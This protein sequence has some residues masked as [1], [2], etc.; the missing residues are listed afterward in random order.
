MNVINGTWR[1]QQLF[2]SEL[3]RMWPERTE[4]QTF[5]EAVAHRDD[6]K[7]VHWCQRARVKP[8]LPPSLPRVLTR[9]LIIIV[10]KWASPLMQMGGWERTKLLS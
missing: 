9:I 4:D 7:V 2:P 6:R 10:D 3:L 8:A 1:K 5:A